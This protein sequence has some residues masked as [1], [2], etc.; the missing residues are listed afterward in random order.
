MGISNELTT[1]LFGTFAPAVSTDI[2]HVPARVVPTENLCRANHNS[3]AFLARAA[4]LLGL[5]VRDLAVLFLQLVATVAR[6]AGPGR[7][8]S[9]VAESVRVKPSC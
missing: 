2:L 7:A 3:W 9:V 6:V 4:I 8:R 1:A 5:R